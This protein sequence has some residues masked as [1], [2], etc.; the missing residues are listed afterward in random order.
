MTWSTRIIAVTLASTLLLGA[1]GTAAMAAENPSPI[2]T[3]G[4]SSAPAI[5]NV[6]IAGN[7][8]GFSIDFDFQQPQSGWAPVALGIYEGSSTRYPF[9]TSTYTT[10]NL[11]SN[12]HT[13]E[14]TDDDVLVPYPTPSGHISR[15]YT[16]SRSGPITVILFAPERAC[17]CSLGLTFVA[18]TTIAP[19]TS[20]LK[21]LTSTPVPTLSGPTKVGST[22]TAA[23]G[24]WAPAPV[25]LTYQW[26]LDGV[27]VSGATGSTFTL[28]TS[29]AGKKVTASV[30]GTKTGYATVKRTSSPTAPVTRALT[31]SPVP[32]LSGWV[33]VGSTLTVTPGTWAPAPVAL[34]YQWS[35]DG[36]VVAGAT[37]RTFTLPASAAG[38]KVTA[39][40][41]GTKDGFSTTRMVSAPTAPVNRALTSTPVPK[42]SGTVRVWST[43]TATPGTWSPGPVGLSYQWNLNGVAV[44]GA[45]GRTFILPKAAA[46]KK[47]T[48]SVTGTKAGYATVKTTSTPTV[49]VKPR[50]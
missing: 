19:L 42:I 9:S 35:V 10:Y 15:T 40:V 43:L 31:A 3:S 13:T 41:T 2:V 18:G 39:A 20:T 4:Q 46:G 6:V 48:V 44:S 30:T 33:R 27:A 49:A 34:T 8:T 45:T 17:D 14:W 24:T 1:G 37:G 7:A 29:A 50:S 28:P 22:L 12:T 23:P 36:L 25:G 21:T 26:A 32:T 11:G 47:V 5:T 16:H 38:K